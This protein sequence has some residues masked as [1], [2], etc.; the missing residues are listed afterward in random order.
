MKKLLVLLFMLTG[1]AISADHGIYLKVLENSP[2]PI[3][4]VVEQVRLNVQESGYTVLAQKGISS[5][6]LIRRADEKKC[7]YR[8]FILVL[9]D[10]AYTDF[11]AS[12]GEKYIVAAFLKI[13]I[14]ESEH[15]VQVNITDPETI[16]RI[17][18]NDL[19]DAQYNA[20]CKQVIPFKTKLISAI[21][22][23]ASGAKVTKAQE[24]VRS[25]EDLREASKDMFM[26]VGPMTFYDDEDQFPVIYSQSTQNVQQD[27]R[28]L[29]ARVQKNLQSFRPSEGDREY[30]WTPKKAD[31]KWKL[32]GMLYTP[33]SSA[34]LLGLSRNRTEA[35]SFLIAG[36]PRADAKNNCPGLDHSAAYPI[37]V[38][39]YAEEGKLI[40]R[41]AR[42]MFRMD[43][44]FWDAGKMAFM[45][46]MNLPKMLDNSIKKA[47]LGNN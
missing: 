40:M 14:Y 18:L 32:T 27:I 13:G 24:P 28:K 26:M 8:G 3:E 12:V 10:P 33:D 7:G 35:L 1:F 25:T 2:L 42:E 17:V 43:M 23:Q 31:L 44:Y 41:T 34:A 39:I 37:E 21:Q 47:L 36:K 19:D 30:Q 38:L 4:K 15:G 29:I 46:Y 9:Q 11:L 16:S 5:P 6:D 20:A 45:E 22:Q